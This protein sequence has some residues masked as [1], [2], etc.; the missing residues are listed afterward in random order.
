MVELGVTATRGLAKRQMTWL[1]SERDVRDIT[2]CLDHA[3][4]LSSLV[5]ELEA[6][7]NGASFSL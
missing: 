7:L 2:S 1:R 5:T 6:W 3:E 4:G